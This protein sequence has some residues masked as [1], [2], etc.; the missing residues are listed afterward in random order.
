VEWHGSAP[1]YCHVP[2]LEGLIA[3]R[4]TPNSAAGSGY[5]DAHIVDA[6][7]SDTVA[8]MMLIIPQ[9][10]GAISTTRHRAARWRGVD[11]LWELHDSRS[12]RCR[13][14]PRCDRGRP[15]GPEGYAEWR[16]VASDVT[17]CKSP[18]PRPARGTS[19][20]GIHKP[21]NGKGS[22]VTSCCGK[23]LGYLTLFGNRGRP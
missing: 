12:H 11:P 20:T 2:N 22:A 17:R 14:C 10:A 1:A 6:S 3:V 7:G 8:T 9:G 21:A 16:A 15:I 4:W 19:T 13:C 5:T 23:G 18:L